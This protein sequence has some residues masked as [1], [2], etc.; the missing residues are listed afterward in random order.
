MAEG[1]LSVTALYTS[2][3]WAWGKCARAELLATV[4]AKRVFDVTNAALAV[5]RLQRPML[6]YLLLHRHAM[7]DHLLRASGATRV[8]ELAAGL[9]QRGAACCGELQYVEVD[10]PHVIERKRGLLERTAEGRTV[11]GQLELVAANVETD[12]LDAYVAPGTFVIAEGLMMY[13][14]GDA[15]RALFAKLRRLGDIQLVFDLVPWDEE[16]SPGL[17]GRALEAVMKRFTGGRTFERDARTRAQVVDELR[18]AGFASV[19]AIAAVDV[20]QAWHL[21]HA[22]RRTQAVVFSARATAA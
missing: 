1:D 3:A 13:L 10:L 2:G 15:R 19:E 17:A 6:P 22:E 21:P 5:A 9:S 16:P 4:D 12:P 8:L 7:I 11:L 14:A 18:A 20:A